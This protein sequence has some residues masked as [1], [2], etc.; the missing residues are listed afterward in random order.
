M[1]CQEC[2]T[3]WRSINVGEFPEFDR[4]VLLVPPSSHSKVFEADRGAI[5]FDVE[6]S[7]DQ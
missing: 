5:S 3:G 6:K 4:R 1:P 2:P 7:V